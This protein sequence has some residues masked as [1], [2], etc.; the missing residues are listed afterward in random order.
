M[1]RAAT[2]DRH[3]TIVLA[4]F[5][6]PSGFGSISEGST[7]CCE[8]IDRSVGLLCGCLWYVF[9]ERIFFLVGLYLSKL[10]LNLL[11]NL[12]FC[13]YHLP[14][15]YLQDVEVVEGLAGSDVDLVELLKDVGEGLLN[16]S[17]VNICKMFG[18]QIF[19]GRS[20]IYCGSCGLER[21]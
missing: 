10:H 21:I 15:E 11:L 12:D 6:E 14:F 18:E 17:H 19:V 9:L 2:C 16:P 5:F 20:Y 13:L 4:A 1:E 3:V 8:Q 7:P